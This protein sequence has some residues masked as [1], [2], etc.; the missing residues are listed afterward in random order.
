MYIAL[1]VIFA[2][3]W[4]LARHD[5]EIRLEDERAWFL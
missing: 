4:E 2:E 5:V 3:F 1:S